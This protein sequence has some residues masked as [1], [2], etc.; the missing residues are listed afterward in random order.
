MENSGSAIKIVHEISEN[1]NSSDGARMLRVM[2]KEYIHKKKTKL[3][4]YYYPSSEIAK[5]SSFP[6]IQAH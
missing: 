6:W 4:I 2:T 3:H 5:E 1:E